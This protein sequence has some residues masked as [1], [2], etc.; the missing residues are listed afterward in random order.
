MSVMRDL[1]MSRKDFADALGVNY[2]YI[3][4]MMSNELLPNGDKNPNH[5]KISDSIKF[6]IRELL[7]SKGIKNSNISDDLP[8]IHVMNVPIINQYAYAGYLEGYFDEEY[9]KE[10]PTYPVIKNKEYK[11]T[12]RIFE[13]K[14]D[15]M[16]DGTDRAIKEYDKLLCRDIQQHHWKNKLHINQY[17][18]I[19]VHKEDGIVVKQI[20]DHDTENGTLT[21]GSFNSFYEDYTIN[22]NDVVKLFNV[23]EIVSRKPRF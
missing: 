11:G 6:K 2:N 19:I 21:L 15:S 12:Y 23:I 9:I 22:I 7:Q 5:R 16:D 1:G 10:L 13:V 14:G 17:L 8:S 20:K 3:G 4:T 18:F